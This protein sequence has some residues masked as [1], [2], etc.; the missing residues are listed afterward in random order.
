M[1]IRAIKLKESDRPH[2]TALYEVTGS[3]EITAEENFS[4]KVEI[5]QRNMAA[6]GAYLGKDYG[7]DCL[8][9]RNLRLE[10]GRIYD[11]LI[12]KYGQGCMYLS[13]LLGGKDRY[14]RTAYFLE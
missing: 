6:G 4:I 3:R 8:Y 2:R 1:A 11:G 7:C 12:S 13:W 10:S 9:Y 14:R 5:T